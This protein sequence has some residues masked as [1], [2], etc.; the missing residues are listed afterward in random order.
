MSSKY[1]AE[2]KAKVA[3]EALSQNIGDLHVIAE[4]YKVTE[5]EII[6]WVKQLKDNAAGLFDDGAEAV[7]SSS[8]KEEAIA[9]E[10]YEISI[11]NEEFNIDLAKGV[12]EDRLNL[13][14]ITKWFSLGVAVIVIAI[15]FLV[16]FAQ[17][18]VSK[19]ERMASESSEFGEVNKLK[20]EQNEILSTFGVIDLDKGIYHIPIDEV[21][22]KMANE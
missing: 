5:K 6:T 12:T 22:D 2:F 13:K 19:A 9:P 14:L 17:H 8:G 16:Q 21:I 10:E 3:L 20:K 15:V 11:Q 4:Q 1:S 7:A 18:S